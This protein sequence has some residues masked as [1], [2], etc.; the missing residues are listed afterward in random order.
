MIEQAFTQYNRYI[1]CPEQKVIQAGD[2]SR[3]YC[4]LESNWC[5]LI[6]GSKCNI[7]EEFLNCPH[8]ITTIIDDK[9]YC[10]ECGK[11][12]IHEEDQ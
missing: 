12:I 10:I 4:K 9:R 6:D 7:Y 2:E 5:V 8:S 3:E 11:E 1:G